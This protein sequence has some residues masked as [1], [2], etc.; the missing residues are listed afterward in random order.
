LGEPIIT[1]AKAL[2]IPRDLVYRMLL[3]VNAAVGHSVERVHAL[4][5][6]YDDMTVQTAEHMVAIWQALQKA[7]RQE[8]PSAAA[9]SEE[10]K[11]ARYQ[12]LLYN[13]EGRARPRA[14]S[15]TT[16]RTPAPQR[17]TDRRDVS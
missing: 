6:L 14:T 8:L 2:R 5:N 12:P 11:P 4:A 1:V 17:S 7:E 13:D 3:F 10:R 9:Q 15:V 16:R